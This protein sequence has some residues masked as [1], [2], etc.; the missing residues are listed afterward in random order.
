MIN[1]ITIFLKRNIRY[2]TPYKVSYKKHKC[3]YGF[4]NA[5]GVNYDNY[6]CGSQSDLSIQTGTINQENNAGI[7]SASL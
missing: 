4:V 2:C 7:I 5:S 1:E 6:L 3:G